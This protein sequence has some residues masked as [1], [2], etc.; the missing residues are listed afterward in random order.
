MTQGTFSAEYTKLNKAQ[1]EAVDAIE[2]PVMVVAGPGTGKT[3]VLTVRMANILDKTDT[4][5]EAILALTY[6]NNAAAEI[7]KRLAELIGMPA[8]RTTITT[9]HG[10]CELIIHEH[11]ERFPEF[12]GKRIADASDQRRIM[13]RIFGRASYLEL[14]AG[15][16]DDPYYIGP[17]LRAIETLKREGVGPERLMELI[18]AE[19]VIISDDPDAISTRGATKGQMKADYKKKLERLDR[20]AELPELYRDYDSE[21]ANAKLYD[22]S[23]LLTR[24]RDA[25]SSDELLRLSLQEQYQYLLID[26]HQDTNAT[27]N[28]IVELLAGFFDTPNLF[29]VGDEKQAVY[30]FQG[31]SLENF[32]YFRDVFRDVKLIVL[33]ENYRASQL[34]LDAAHG[35]RASEKPLKA[36]QQYADEPVG[37]F[38]ASDTDAQYYAVGRMISER[39]QKGEQPEQIAVLYRNN[40]DGQAL[41]EMLARMNIAYSLEAKTN[42]IQDPDIGRLLFLLEAVHDY[43]EP[44]PLYEALLV[45]WLGIPPLDVYKLRTFCGRDRN[46]YSVIASLSL[47]KEAGIG[48]REKLLALSE[49][50]GQWHSMAKQESPPVALEAVV[51]DSGCLD[52]LIAHREGSQKMSRLHTIYEIARNLTHGHRDA[53]LLD[54]VVQLRYVRDKGI[55]LEVSNPRIPGRVRLMTAHTAKGLEFDSVILIDCYES[56]WPARKRTS[57][58]ELPASVYRLGANPV[59][60]EGEADTEERNLFFVALTRARRN[61][62]ICWP[63]RN[64][65]GTE[66]QPTRYLE[67]I[68]PGLVS[69]IDTAEYE[70]AYDN[71]GHVRLGRISAT[72]PELADHD[73]LRQ[74]FIRQG[75][76]ATALNNYLT[77]PWQYFYRNL[78]RI[79]EAMNVHLMYG[80]SVDRALERFFEQRNAGEKVGKKDMLGLFRQEMS[81][82]PFATQAFTAF[83]KRGNESL[84]GWYEKWSGQWLARSDQQVKITGIAVPDVPDITVNGKIDMIEHLDASGAV[85]VVDFKTGKPKTRND[86]LG[87]TKSSSGDYHRQ[88][89]FYR[90]L[91]DRYQDGRYRMSEGVLDFI[92]PDQ[93]GEYHREPFVIEAEDA[94][95]LMEQVQKVANEILD[96]SFWDARCGDRSCEYCHRR[97]LLF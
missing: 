75:L 6:T 52:S 50:L 91:T 13:E 96:L 59:A 89:T 74:M 28:R 94:D 73:F 9:F 93:K 78:V 48:A 15:Y 95:A 21:L 46:P 38:A 65:Q 63:Q 20:L 40:A 61:A 79:P 60:D 55:R 57:P 88:L 68:R 83:S 1:K 47:M 11:E 32:L 45:P 66:L 41:A 58:L 27:Q 85:R 80:N 77:C 70:Q 72:R 2:G 25:L 42:V 31:A 62:V 67:D 44:G 7:R 43:G 34:L 24:V 3:K 86:I 26:E 10:L 39:I 29:I 33:N 5:P 16:G 35:I 8:Y 49:R 90:M 87:K 22:F 18:D 19:R 82:Q 76:S 64:Q 37:L 53:T 17:A 84:S 92:D 71:E 54:L 56:H 36:R 30:R 51:T 12:A 4:E 81:K 14:L 97:E 23:D 69:T